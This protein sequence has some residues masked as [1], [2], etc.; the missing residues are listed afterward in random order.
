MFY[1]VPSIAAIRLLAKPHEVVSMGHIAVDVCKLSYLIGK[2][3]I[4]RLFQVKDCVLALR[5]REDAPWVGDDVEAEKS[6]SVAESLQ[7]SFHPVDENGIEAAIEII[8][9]EDE[10]MLVSNKAAEEE[11]PLG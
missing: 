11:L 4:L 3:V 10:W 9:V 2:N 5:Q 1:F 7:R 8:E 6:L